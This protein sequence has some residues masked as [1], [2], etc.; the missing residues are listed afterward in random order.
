LGFIVDRIFVP[1]GMM[2]FSYNPKKSGV[3]NFLQTMRCRL[4]IQSLLCVFVDIS[5]L[6]RVTMRRVFT[7]IAGIMVL[8]FCLFCSDDGESDDEG[9]G[10]GPTG[11]AAPTVPVDVFWSC[12]CNYKCGLTLSVSESLP[13]CRPTEAEAQQAAEEACNAKKNP[14]ENCGLCSCQCTTNNASCYR[15]NASVTGSGTSGATGGA[16]STSSLYCCALEK[17]CSKSAIGANPCQADTTLSDAA[18]AGNEQACQAALD[19]AVLDVQVADCAVDPDCLY[20]EADAL[21]ECQ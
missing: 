2:A 14:A 4:R 15:G 11:G 21:A 1:H 13:A 7:V 17:L 19:N 18:A 8:A 12:D 20:T 5:A 6:W 9:G 3:D 10:N 16:A